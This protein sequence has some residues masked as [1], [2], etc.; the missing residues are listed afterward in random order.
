MHIPMDYRSSCRLRQLNRDLNQWEKHYQKRILQSMPVTV[1]VT[2]GSQC[3]LR[4]VFC[5]DR[6]GKSNQRYED[7]TLEAFQNSLLEPL[8][9]ASE[10]Q[11]YGWGEPFINR[12]YER[13]FD[14]V[15]SNF[16]GIVIH[17][18][19]NGTL[20][21]KKWAEKLVGYDRCS[22]NVSIDAATRETYASLK[23]RDL[24]DQVIDN[25]RTLSNMRS[26]SGKST[27]FIMLSFVAMTK[28]ID[29]LPCFVELASELGADYILIQDL[30]II[31]ESQAELSLTNDPERAYRAFISASQKAEERNITL[32]SFVSYPVDYFSQKRL[33]QWE[34]SY[35]PASHFVDYSRSGTIV[36]VNPYYSITDC[37]DPW[38]RFMVGEDGSVGVC[39]RS[40]EV[41]GNLFE[42]S[43]QEIW[44]GEMYRYYR[45]T[46]NTDFPPSQCA[47]CPIKMGCE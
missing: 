16:P 5:T 32:S 20:L 18:S 41:M 25:V 27:V 44:N 34:Q 37:F 4:C 12:D 36:P 19:T 22:V 45:G 46:I 9:L 2:T 3:N 13:I 26:E 7:L 35:F 38:E 29:E 6:E 17:I 33:P 1:Q 24:F 14:F 39:C 10:V 15:A 42:Q 8:Y 43:F 40:S 30:M 31:E 21:S 28:N 23:K 11:L 47:T